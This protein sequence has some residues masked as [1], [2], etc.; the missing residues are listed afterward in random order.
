MKDRFDTYYRGFVKK[1]YLLTTIAFTLFMVFIDTNNLIK[2]F[3]T[4][5]QRNKLRNDIE[6]FKQRIATDS[7]NLLELKTNPEVLE[8]F[9][10]EQY[11]MKKDG[12]DIFIIVKD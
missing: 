6:Y 1:K 12:E 9:A 11:F 5:K 2:R 7:R 8:K 3:E 10:R 4:F